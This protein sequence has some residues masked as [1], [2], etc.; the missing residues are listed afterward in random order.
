[1]AGFT[2]CRLIIS[3]DDTFLTGKYKCTLMVVVDMTV[4]NQ[5]LPLS[6]TLV[7]GKNNESCSWFL[8]LVKKHVLGSDRQVC[9]IS[10]C[11]GLL[12]NA[13]EHFEGYPPL[14]HR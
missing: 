10:D 9:M 4:K 12:N 8:S 13:K 5:F 11:R 1:M 14:I 7:E 2:D 3:V 6:F